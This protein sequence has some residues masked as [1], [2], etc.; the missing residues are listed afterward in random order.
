[1]QRLRLVLFVF[2]LSCAVAAG[3]AQAQV[4]PPP[5]SAFAVGAM[6]GASLRLGTEAVGA[7][8]EPGGYFQP[9]G[10]GL[11]FLEPGKALLWRLD[12][13]LNVLFTLGDLELCGIAGVPVAGVPELGT[14]GPCDS[15]ELAGRGRMRLSGPPL[16]GLHGQLRP[17][18]IED[19]HSPATGSVFAISGVIR[20]EPGQQPG[21]LVLLLQRRTTGMCVHKN[22][23][24]SR[25]GT[26]Y[27]QGGT[28]AE[29]VG[30]LAYQLPRD[31]VGN[32]VCAD[33]WGQV[34]RHLRGAG[35]GVECPVPPEL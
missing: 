7:C 1:M 29:L 33:E 30:V 14:A 34:R 20:G 11:G 27:P 32:T 13:A 26:T 17:Y 22:H 35:A 18:A 12:A 5:V 25:I 16:L 8:D 3:P 24:A 2:V 21:R 9:H 31:T 4:Q 15:V 19:V 10:D 6:S 28:S 23:E